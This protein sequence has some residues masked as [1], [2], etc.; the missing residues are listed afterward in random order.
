MIGQTLCSSQPTTFTSNNTKGMDMIGQT[1]C[2]SQPTTF[3]C[4][5]TKG[6]RHKLMDLAKVPVMLQMTI[7]SCGNSHECHMFEH[8]I[9][10]STERVLSIFSPLANNYWCYMYQHKITDSITHTMVDLVQP[11]GKQLLVLNVSTQDHRQHHTYHGGSCSGH[12]QTTSGL[13]YTDT[14][15]QAV[16]DILWWTLPRPQLI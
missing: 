12:R 11:T 1:L 2:S 8:R 15:S 13:T 10:D 5:N 4:D 7:V 3:T 6:I 9:T 16:S 14:R